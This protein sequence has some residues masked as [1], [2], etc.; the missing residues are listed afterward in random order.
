MDVRE[1]NVT[2]LNSH[3]S[4]QIHRLRNH[5]E[6]LSWSVRDRAHRRRRAND[7]TPIA[8]AAK[9]GPTHNHVFGGPAFE[10][11]T[12]DAGMQSVSRVRSSP[13]NNAPEASSDVLVGP[14]DT[15]RNGGT[16][17]PRRSLPWRLKNFSVS[18]ASSNSRLTESPMR[19]RVNCRFLD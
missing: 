4:R 15:G 13:P 7:D 11:L 1:G 16:H 2:F 14:Q 19:S 9:R 17:S 3:I 8:I 12:S 6:I 10:A 5:A 18:V